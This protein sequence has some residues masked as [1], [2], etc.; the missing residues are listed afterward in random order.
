MQLLTKTKKYSPHLGK[1]LNHLLIVQNLEKQMFY[2]ISF[3]INLT[4]IKY[5]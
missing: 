3:P 5:T 1:I 2:Y 4:L